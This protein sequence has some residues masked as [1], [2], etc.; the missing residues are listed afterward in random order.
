[1]TT[2][3]IEIGGTKLQV[4]AVSA[5]GDVVRCLGERVVAASGADGIRHA[6]ARLLVSI[7]RETQAIGHDVA[8]A[9]IGFGGPVRR[10]RGEVIESFHVGGWSGFPLAAWVAET[11]RDHLG[12]IPVVLENDANAAA[13][14]EA[15][16]G[17]GRD[18]RVV[19]YSNVGSGI[20][21]GLVIAGRIYHGRA[22]GEMELGHLRIAAAGGVLEHVASGWALDRLVRERVAVDPAGDLAKAAAGGVPSARLL[23]PVLAAG[24]TA[25]QEIL[26]GAAGHYAG[27]LAQVVQL[28][29]PDVIVLGGGVSLIG[30]PWRRSVE[31]HLEPLVM[32]ALRPAPPV[33][34]AALGDMV[35]PVGAAITA[36]GTVAT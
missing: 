8:A 27:A 21:A 5:A 17:A 26:D 11:V 13:L 28:L 34:L 6:L 31:R 4:A 29:N 25:A 1:M 2:L 24:S 7:C 9:G 19:V 22:G 30:E 18:S 23:G 16:V 20:G 32:D 15:T 33:R 36:L 3:G 14:A 12:S 10:D 35:V